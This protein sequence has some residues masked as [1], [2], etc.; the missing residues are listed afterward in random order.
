MSVVSAAAVVDVRIDVCFD[1][2]FL[3]CIKAFPQVYQWTTFGITSL[4]ER[5]WAYQLPILEAGSKPR[6]EAVE[7]CSVLERTLAYAHTGNARV[8]ATKLMRPLWLVQ[9]LLEQ[10][11][12]TFAPSVR[13]TTTI[14]NP[15]AISAADWPTSDNLNVPAIAS[16]R[17]QVLTYGND[18]FEVRSPAIFQFLLILMT[19]SL[20]TPGL[21]YRHTKRAST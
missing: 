16:K 1:V 3:R 19:S 4:L 10:G 8:L 14:N 2:S 7:L 6:H 18:H 17:S 5:L 11:L 12:P 20:T 21:F 15:I 9:S 13:I